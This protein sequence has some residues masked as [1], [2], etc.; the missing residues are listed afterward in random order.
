MSFV[1]VL[2]NLYFVNACVNVIV[3]NVNIDVNAS[4]FVF[5]FFHE[6]FCVYVMFFIKCNFGMFSCIYMVLICL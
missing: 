4:V 2:V 1:Y 3:V 6:W 5:V